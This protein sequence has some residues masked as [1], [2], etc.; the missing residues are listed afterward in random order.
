MTT[1]PSPGGG[2]VTSPLFAYLE[3][4]LGDNDFFVG[5]KL[6]IADITVASADT[7][8]PALLSRLGDKVEP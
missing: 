8:S 2:C 1:E 7:A 6:T 5:N 3:K 4:E